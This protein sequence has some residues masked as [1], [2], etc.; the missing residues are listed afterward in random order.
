MGHPGDSRPGVLLDTLAALLHD[1]I[2]VLG[3]LLALAARL[4]A[5]LL[6]SLVTV[7]LDPRRVLLEVLAGARADPAACVVL[8]LD[9][10]GIA[11]GG[12]RGRGGCGGRRRGAVRVGRLG[13]GVGADAS[14]LLLDMGRHLALVVLALLLQLP[15]LCLNVRLHRAG[16]CRP[17]R[18]DLGGRRR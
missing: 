9:A 2:N 3:E 5:E 7:A 10:P 6:R 12:D 4:T 1:L 11:A 14:G 8:C 15:G 13:L 17:L 18:L 16:L